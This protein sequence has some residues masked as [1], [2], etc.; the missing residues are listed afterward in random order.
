MLE[1]TP[2]LVKK[3]KKPLYV[4]LY[5][6]LKTE[7]LSRRIEAGAK[8]P[9][10]RKLSAHL[11][12]SQNTIQAAYHQLQAEGYVESKVRSGIYVCKLEGDLFPYVTPP[13]LKYE[14]QIKQDVSIDFNQ[15]KI[16]LVNFPYSKWRKLSMESLFYEE[17]EIYYN[18]NPKGEEDLRKAIARYLFQSRGVKCSYEQIIIGAGTQYM[19]SLLSKL[20][21][22]EKIVA[23]EDPGYHRSRIAFQD[24]YMTVEPISLDEEGMSVEILQKSKANIAYVTPSHQ[25]P[26]GLIMPISRRMELLQWAEKGERYIIEDDY[27]GEFRYKGKPI[28]SMQ[29]MDTNG[30]VIYMGTLSKSLIPSI[31]LSYVVLPMQLL[32]LF[33]EKLLINKQT[34]SRLHQN[35]LTKFMQKGF[36][37]SHLNK[38]RTVYRKKQQVL[39]DSISEY[40][41]NEVRMIGEQSGLHILLTFNNDLSESAL[42]HLAAEKG[43]IV[44]P[45]SIYYETVDYD[46]PATLLLGF[47]GLSEKEI[48]KGVKLLSEAWNIIKSH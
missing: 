37:E 14:D 32:E 12:I 11:G 16:D 31:R 33:N 9:S 46:K 1:I 44:Y 18:G 4:Q 39:S 29:S 8:L 43:V 3:R 45:T 48:S 25:F 30:R 38:M 6:Y 40:F 47:G 10:K 22:T 5:T 2:S 21:S 28:P 15:G 23:M 27:D 17:S 36:W 13:N 42:I 24:N 35:T 41:D 7:I 19:I 34:V 26:T 20:F